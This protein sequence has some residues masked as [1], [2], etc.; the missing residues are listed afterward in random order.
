MYPPP[1][2]CVCYA[3][4]PAPLQ[5]NEDFYA[6]LDD[7]AASGAVFFAVCRGKVSEGLDFADK[8]GRAVIITGMPYAMKLDPKVPPRLRIFD[9]VLRGWPDAED[10]LLHFSSR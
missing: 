9:C 10:W 3:K 5:A 6:K 4:A 2:S 1:C 7:S 8:A